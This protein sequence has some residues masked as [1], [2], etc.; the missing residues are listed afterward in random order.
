MMCKCGVS[1]KSNTVCRGLATIGSYR[2]LLGCVQVNIAGTPFQPSEMWQTLA[3]SCGRNLA[4]RSMTHTC[5]FDG[6]TT[7]MLPA[8]LSVLPHPEGPF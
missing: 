6:K 5:P 7:R 2:Q 4:V 1:C 8:V 3:G